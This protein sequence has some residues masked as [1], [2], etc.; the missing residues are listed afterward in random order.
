MTCFYAIF[1]PLEGTGEMNKVGRPCD[2][3][4]LRP[5]SASLLCVP[6]ILCVEN[7]VLHGV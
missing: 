2:S 5:C 6:N 3:A 7:R 4:S 1:G